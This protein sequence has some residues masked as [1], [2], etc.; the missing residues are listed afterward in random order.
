MSSPECKEKVD[1]DRIQLPGTRETAEP[2]RARGG[3]KDGG[4]PHID[5]PVRPQAPPGDLPGSPQKGL[6]QPSGLT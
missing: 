4:L 6:A 1:P 3:Q 2:P 5:V